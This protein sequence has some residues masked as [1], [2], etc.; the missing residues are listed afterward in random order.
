MECGKRC[1][2]VG[3]C[4]THKRLDGPAAVATVVSEESLLCVDNGA[5]EGRTGADMPQNG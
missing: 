2:W 3:L 4:A 1:S 5:L